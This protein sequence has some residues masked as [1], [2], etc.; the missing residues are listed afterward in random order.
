MGRRGSRLVVAATLVTGFG[1]WAAGP[2][3]AL[4]DDTAHVCSG[5]IQSPGTPVGS[6]IQVVVKGVCF[7]DAGPAIVHHELSFGPDL[8][9]RAN[10]PNKVSGKR[11]GQCVRSTPSTLGG[12]FGPPGSF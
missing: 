3:T 5:T 2:S 8:Y 7:V 11:S 6:F 9:P 4:A 10:V 1:A 12:P